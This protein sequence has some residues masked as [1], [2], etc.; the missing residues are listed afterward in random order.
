MHITII[1]VG[2]QGDVQPYLALG[3]GLK[4]AGHH[5]TIATL[6]IFKESVESAG[7]RFAE[8][9]GNPREWLETDEGLAFI[10]S[11]PS[12]IGFFQGLK[13]F[14]AP[15][16]ESLLPT[17]FEAC[18]GTDVILY[19]SLAFSGP[20]IA[21]KLGCA[22]FPLMLQPIYPTREF[23][24]VLVNAEKTS[25]TFNQL[26]HFISDQILHHSS[27]ASVNR[28]RRHSL[29][30]PPTP[31]LGIYQNMRKQ[32]IPQFLGYSEHVLAR[33]TDWESHVHVTG[34][35]FL[36]RPDAWQPSPE[37]VD[38]LRSGPPPVYIGFGSMTSRRPEQLTALIIQAL[39][40]T[41]QR[42]LLLGGWSKLGSAAL[43]K[44]ILPLESV[45][46]DWLFPQVSAVV[47]HGGAGTTAAGLRAG[48]P[49]IVTPF[50]ADQFFWA[51]RVVKLGAGPDFIPHAQL[52]ADNL[53][54]AIRAVVG[55]EAM[56]ERARTVGEKI[57]A[58][59]GVSKM[60][61]LFEKAIRN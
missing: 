21:E 20:H 59:D 18:Q 45:P 2:S 29:N 22:S 10:E 6:S 60:V 51:R 17:S 33:P 50:F 35:W 12:M 47:H 15:V 52:T 38:F 19:S 36:K 41:G 40:S 26:S 28:W 11:G 44:T 54:A 16:L 48:V 49:A 27:R 23:P 13:K 34:Y 39:Q 32:R 30:L 7:L 4:S 57:R 56:R 37:L 5:V 46:H 25:R 58:E 43:P 42:G 53:A 8:V 31:F 3:I 14:M 1:A 61:H 9:K 55:N 24:S